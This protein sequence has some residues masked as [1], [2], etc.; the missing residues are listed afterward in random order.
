LFQR[1]VAKKLG[2]TA[3]TVGNWESNATTPI[4][5]Y[6]KAILHFLGYNPFPPAKTLGEQLVHYRNIHGLSQRQFAER[7]GVDQCTLAA[8]ER[9]RH[10]PTK[11]SMKI[12]KG[13]FQPVEEAG[14]A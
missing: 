8:W 6:Y 11:K 4:C 9:G 2:V 5:R 13:F 14:R 1:E 12:I 7:L 10:I 3:S